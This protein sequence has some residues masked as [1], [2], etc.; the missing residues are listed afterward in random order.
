MNSAIEKIV[1]PIQKSF[2]KVKM[3]A[4]KHSPD[5][6][7][8]A[9][10]GSM[11]VGTGLAIKASLDVK[12]ILTDAAG[13]LEVIRHDEELLADDPDAKSLVK[14]KVKVYFHY[15]LDLAR[16]YTPA[17]LCV[18]GGA[19]SVFKGHNIL[20]KRNVALAASYASLESAYSAYKKRV[21]DSLGETKAEELDYNLT[22]EKV[23]D[24][25]GKKHSVTYADPEA[26]LSMYAYPFKSCYPQTTKEGKTIMVKNPYFQDEE[27]FDISWIKSAEVFAN[28]QLESKGYV[29]LSD[30]YER[31]GITPRDNNSELASRV[32]GWVDDGTVHPISFFSYI[33]EG[34]D[35]YEQTEYLLRDRD[36]NVIL[37]FNVE[38]NVL[39]MM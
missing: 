9:G 29:Y 37:D 21:E 23:K 16:M 6:L 38:G 22:T 30:V 36:G 25:K 35:P 28:L 39:D 3:K 20:Q 10:V 14:D 17:A 1:K 8:V 32:M 19:A 27:L 7:V 18:F 11:V 15:G 26:G 2:R 12:D 34:V 24:D 4:I 33:P 13:E 5:I 31:L